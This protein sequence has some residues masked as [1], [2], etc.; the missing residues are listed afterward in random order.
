MGLNAQAA[1]AGVQFLIVKRGTEF[2]TIRPDGQ[3][4]ADFE[5]S[6]RRPVTLAPA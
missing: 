5:R 2:T 1:A 3:T 4:R 6:R